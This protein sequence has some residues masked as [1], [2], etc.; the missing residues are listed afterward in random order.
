MATRMARRTGSTTGCRCRSTSTATDI[1]NMATT[2]LSR[3]ARPQHRVFATLFKLQSQGLSAQP[4]YGGPVL[5]LPEPGLQRAVDGS[6]KFVATPAGVLVYN[7]T[8]VGRSSRADRRAT[9]HFR[10]NLVILSGELDPVF[11]VGS[12]NELL[13]VG[14]QRVSS[15]ARKRHRVRM[16]TP[17]SGVVAITR[18]R[19][20]CTATRRLRSTATRAARRSTACSST[21]T[22]H[23]CDDAG[24]ADLQ[25]LYKPMSGLPVEAGFAR[26]RRRR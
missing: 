26:D 12:Y 18:R 7:N 2:A 5:F 4:M 25:R 3:M 20:S 10:N 21:S 23:E 1:F 8:F 16:D 15:V 14:L 19:R 6:L 9:I 17:A 24:Q 11:A 13:D 22:R